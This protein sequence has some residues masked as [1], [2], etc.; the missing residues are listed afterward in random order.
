M[1][2]LEFVDTNVLLYAYDPSAG[3]RHERARSLV[4]RL[5]RDRVGA[6]S[7]QVL[8]EFHV[9]ATSKITRPLSLAAARERI[10]T[11]ARWTV[12]VPAADD[13]LAAS[14]LAE[15]HRLSFWDAMIV[16]SAASLGCSLLHTEDLN[17][18]QVIEDVKIT[19]PFA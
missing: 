8:Q 17:H 16:A 12:H 9:N 10:A 18:G 14:Q 3:R 2:A 13:V 5:G 4:G 7:I 19:N 6:V 15:R 11:L 1:S